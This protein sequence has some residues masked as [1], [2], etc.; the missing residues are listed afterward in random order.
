MKF[1]K[2]VLAAAVVF[3]F[4][5]VIGAAG[6]SDC[7]ACLADVVPR[8]LCGAGMACVSLFALAIIERNA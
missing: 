3:G 5:L 8:M 4:V 1:V 7:G 6:D 2:F